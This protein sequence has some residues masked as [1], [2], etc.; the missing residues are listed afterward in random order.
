MAVMR[1]I[2]RRPQDT[3]APGRAT[4]VPSLSG[5][6]GLL[7]HCTLVATVAWPFHFE[8]TAP[9]PSFSA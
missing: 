4:T 7:S 5:E 2:D 8:G 3:T 6:T 1:D 9:Q